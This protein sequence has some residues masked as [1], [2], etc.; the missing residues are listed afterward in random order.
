[1]YRYAEARVVAR[2]RLPGRF[3]A[4]SLG[5]LHPQKGYDVLLD[6]LASVPGVR[7]IGPAEPVERSAAISFVMSGVHPH[8]VGQVL[9]AEGIEVRVGH[10][11]AKPTCVRYAVPA[12]TRASFYVY[13]TTGEVDA[14]VR[15]LERA[16]KVFG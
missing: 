9:D 4:G 5:R 12:T 6:A 11:C 2:E 8:D 16:K 13:T 15:A 14:L 3:V 1:M 7:I 10:H